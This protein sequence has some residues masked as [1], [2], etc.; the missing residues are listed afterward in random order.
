MILACDVGGTK[1]RLALYSDRDNSLQRQETETFS[2]HDY[3]NLHEI[4]KIFL[5]K[6]KASIEKACFG[7][8][9]PVVDGLAQTTNLPWKIN[10]ELLSKN[11]EIRQVKLVNDLAATTAAILHLSHEDLI[12]LHAGEPSETEEKKFAMLAPG[13]GLGQGFLVIN[14]N[15]KHVL[16]SEGGHVDFSPCN[17]LEIELFNYLKN[18]F[19]HVSYERILSGPGLVN[20]YNFL[21]D[22]NH[23]DEPEELT[24]RF[25]NEDQ[26]AVI[27][28]AGQ[29]AEFEICVKALDIFVSVLG[30]QA[31]NLVLALLTTSGVYLGGGIPPKIHEKLMEG[32]I[33]ASY[34]N[35]GRLSYLVEKTPLYIVRDDYAA[36]LGAASIAGE[37]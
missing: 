10:E 19:G 26:A 11:L 37:L 23:A 20:I 3:S 30:A 35:K 8:P 13:T 18:K 31:G 36:L 1:V 25:Q 17:N 16:A 27:S 24:K 5:E 7:V 12:V 2:S 29:A 15:G 4:V 32:A 33:V 9:G 21:K 14:S 28:N 22:T 34:L 6:N